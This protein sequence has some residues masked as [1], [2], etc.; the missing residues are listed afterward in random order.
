MRVAGKSWV[1]LSYVSCLG[2]VSQFLHDDYAPAIVSPHMISHR[3]NNN[4]KKKDDRLG[5]LQR[6]KVTMSLIADAESVESRSDSFKGPTHVR[7]N[8]K[9]LCQL[10]QVSVL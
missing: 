5:S 3:I 7:Q 6:V 2:G 1:I 4:N 9:I 8:I 10:N